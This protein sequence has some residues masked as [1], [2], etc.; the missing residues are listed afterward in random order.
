MRAD[1]FDVIIILSTNSGYRAFFSHKHY[2]YSSKKVHL[3]TQNKFVTFNIT[4]KL[5]LLTD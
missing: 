4:I 2:N 5:R 1:Y 3:D